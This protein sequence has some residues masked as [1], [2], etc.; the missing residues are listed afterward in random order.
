MGDSWLAEFGALFAREE[1]SKPSSTPRYSSGGGYSGGSSFGSPSTPEFKLDLG[2]TRDRLSPFPTTPEQSVDYL[3]SFR[4]TPDISLRLNP[5]PVAPLLT[6]DRKPL[7]FEQ[8]SPAV[9]IGSTSNYEADLAR[10]YA[11]WVHWERTGAGSPPCPPLI[12]RR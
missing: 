11:D 8:P 9:A 2:V 5:E 1:P 7:N 12:K 3:A 10:F 4:R 6:F